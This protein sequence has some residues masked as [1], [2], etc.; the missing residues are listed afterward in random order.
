MNSI[1]HDIVNRTNNELYIGVVGSVRSGKST[2][3][4]KFMELKVIPNIDDEFKNKVID[5]LPQSSAGKNIMTVEPK[6]VP[7]NPATINVDSDINFSVRLV[8]CVGY[9]MK[10]AKGYL[11]ED[12]SMKLVKTPWFTDDI[13]FI[14]A[15]T[16]GTKKVI[17][18]HSHIGLLITSDGSFGEFE[19]YE[20]QEVE[21]QII[22]EMKQLNKPFVIIM[23]TNKP[24]D[25]ETINLC[26]NLE[27]KYNISVLPINVNELNNQDIDNI[28]LASLNEFD[29]T[30]ININAPNWLT[31]LDDDNEH[32]QLFN[33]VIKEVT[34]EYRKFKEVIYIQEK[35]KQCS[36]F[37][38]VSITSIDSGTGIVEIELNCYDELYN[39]IISSIVGD[40]LNDK[41]EFV[42]FLEE[43]K[44]A[45]EEYSK[46]QSALE[47]VN[48]TGYGIA[49]PV[50]SDM[51]LEEPS[52][53]K[54]GSRY[55]IKLKAVAP[56]IHM[57]KVDVESLFEPIIG[58]EEQSNKLLEKI[59]GDYEN[60]HNSIWSSEI[61]GRKLSEVVN[62]GIRA[63]LYLI[64]D[65]I[66]VKMKECLEKI[67]NKGK[68]GLLAIVL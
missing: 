40:A 54:Q 53:V 10:N 13:P 49:T 44:H 47:S 15:A 9:V 12:G 45:K 61:F 8:D 37:E 23:N 51:M 25:E 24:N 7:S 3:I 14:E 5:E 57:I 41:G 66:Q 35:L 68:G 60:D 56:S 17:E 29:I 16:I 30:K 63:K 42:K 52:I 26:K 59:M 32:K 27:E 28:L 19:R 55:G 64:P 2:F 48:T 46:Y 34:G 58:T 11:N 67:V 33:N 18:N 62:D 38:N 4:R 50:L 36:L 6:F 39:E 22:E 43:C 65:N 20:Y 1:M 21:E 31:Y